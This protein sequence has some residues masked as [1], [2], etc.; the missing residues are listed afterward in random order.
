[1]KI[2]PALS[3]LLALSLLLAACQ[4]FDPIGLTPQANTTPT[5]ASPVPASSIKLTPA[6]PSPT[7]LPTP[8]LVPVSQL[9]VDVSDLNGIPLR[10][11]RTRADYFHDN[12]QDDLF[13]EL[14]ETFSRD[15]PWGITVQ[16]VLFEDYGQLYDRLQHSLYGE[17]PDLIAGYNYQAARLDASG[18]VLVDLNLYTRDVE[19]GLSSAEL[20]DFY[21]L[22][23]GQDE[24]G[25]KLTG[26]PFY[27]SGQGLYYNNTWGAELGFDSPPESV[28]DFERQACAA[29]LVNSA[30]PNDRSGGWAINTDAP[31]LLGWIFAFGGEASPPGGRGYT[32][33][34]PAAR[35]AFA[36]L[37]SLGAQ[38]CAWVVESRYPNREFA[39]RQALFVAGSLSGLPFQQE[40]LAEAGSSDRW[41][42]LPFPASDE[43]QP[44]LVIYGPSLSVLESST[45]RELAAWLFIKWLVQPENQARWVEAYGVFPTRASAVPLLSGY[46][47]SHPQWS[48]ALELL[49]HGRV[50]PSYPSWRAVRWALSDAGSFLF[51]PFLSAESLPSLLQELE[52][53][54]AEL[55]S[56]LR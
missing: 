43:G 2:L 30:N 23:W 53:T 32:F 41:T 49:P 12:Q 24:L 56:Q 51:S 21:P 11:W 47:A 16:T 20:E 15:N 13:L 44:A 37:H 35:E 46:Q 36:F 8:T 26:I 5:A 19:W 52:Q 18:Q 25:Q 33:D 28:E 27:R 29:A 42:F 10:F 55:H 3:A 22:F 4:G 14:T 39:E 17:R 45:A 50:E 31:T 54:A 40:A 1:M 38:G 34:T 6:A 48:A 9:D 7:Q